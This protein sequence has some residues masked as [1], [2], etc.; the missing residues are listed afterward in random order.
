MKKFTLN[1]TM[2]NVIVTAYFVL[3][4]VISSLLVTVV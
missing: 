2:A 4:G 1:E 3:G